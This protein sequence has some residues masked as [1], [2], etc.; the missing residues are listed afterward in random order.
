M[1]KHSSDLSGCHLRF[2]LTR[3]AT[4][5]LV[6]MKLLDPCGRL[7]ELH[8]RVMEAGCEVDPV[9]TLGL[10]HTFLSRDDETVMRPPNFVGFRVI[11]ILAKSDWICAFFI[12]CETWVPAFV[13]KTYIPDFCRDHPSMK[14]LLNPCGNPILSRNCRPRNPVKALFVPITEDQVV[15]LQALTEHGCLKAVVGPT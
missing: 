8:T 13:I 9:W 2:R 3:M 7:A 15:E 12:S 10:H 14:H 6:N 5:D 1:T 4:S 11:H